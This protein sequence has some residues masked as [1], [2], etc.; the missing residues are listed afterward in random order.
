MLDFTG[1]FQ[2]YAL[3]YIEEACKGNL[4]ISNVRNTD[5]VKAKQFL[6]YRINNLP[7]TFY[8]SQFSLKRLRLFQRL[9]TLLF[10]KIEPFDYSVIGSPCHKEV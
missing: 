8:L 2:L 3:I 7:K 6:I 10:C 1:S 5:I 9:K 4:Q